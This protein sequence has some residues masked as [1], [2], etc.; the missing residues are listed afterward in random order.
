MKILQV[1]PF[2]PPMAPG[3]VGKFADDLVHSLIEQ[4]HKVT[5]ITSSLGKNE[6]KKR[7][8]IFLKSNFKVY[9]C[10]ISFKL[11]PSILASDY[12]V[13]HVHS[14]AFFFPDI[15]S[16]L[17]LFRI[18]KKPAILTLHGVIRKYDL[19]GKNLV[20]FYYLILGGIISKGY[21]KIVVLT[22]ADKEFLIKR[23]VKNEKI[24]IIANGIDI[25]KYNIIKQKNILEKRYKIRNK[26]LILF[27][28][29]LNYQKN[30]MFFLETINQLLVPK[31]LTEVPGLKIPS[32]KT[33]LVVFEPYT[34]ESL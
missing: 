23:G 9:N 17:K 10:P 6:I 32:I 33:A 5:V 29:R 4:K 21:S 13:I 7:D 22:K 8:I 19:I 15:P 31:S 25:I 14:G 24:S 12:D 20:R 26:K 1:T 34:V 16:L 2:Y 3:G 18:I 27:V 30:I 28:G 11:I